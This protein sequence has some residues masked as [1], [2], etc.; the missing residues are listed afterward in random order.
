PPFLGFHVLLSDPFWNKLQQEEKE[1]MTEQM[2]HHHG[3]YPSVHKMESQDPSEE[4]P[5][6]APEILH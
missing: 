1:A 6:L 3:V 4:E 5:M 2:L